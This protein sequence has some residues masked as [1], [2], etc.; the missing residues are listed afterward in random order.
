M[1]ATQS[2]RPHDGR[3]IARSSARYPT[4]TRSMTSAY[5]RA[6]VAY[7]MA[8]GDAESSSTAAQATVWVP[9]GC[10][11]AAMRRSSRRRPP[12]QAG[13]SARTPKSPES[14]RTASLPVPNTDIQTCSSA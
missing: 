11:P 2:S 1:T 6:S 7:R 14:E 12:Y 4:N 13:I 10:S 9:G 3:S 5:M 8:N